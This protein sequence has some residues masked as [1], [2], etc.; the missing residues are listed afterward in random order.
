MRTGDDKIDRLEDALQEWARQ[1]DSVPW[2][3]G[4]QMDTLLAAG[5]NVINHKLGRKPRGWWLTRRIRAGGAA[6]YPSETASTDKTL[7]L[8]AAGAEAV[9]IWIW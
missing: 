6:S 8:D 7:T 9:S 3:D 2:L 5:S 4:V 1:F